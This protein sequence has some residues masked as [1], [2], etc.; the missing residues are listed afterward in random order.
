MVSAEEIKRND[1]VMVKPLD[2]AKALFIA[3]V[4]YLFENKTGAKRVHGRWLWYVF[5]INKDC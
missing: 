1:C 2:P 3:Q 4:I 5:M